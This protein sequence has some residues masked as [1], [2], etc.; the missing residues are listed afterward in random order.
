MALTKSGAKRTLIVFTIVNAAAVLTLASAFSFVTS[1]DITLLKKVLFTYSSDTALIRARAISTG[2]YTGS[3]MSA[4][5]YAK[6]LDT[7]CRAERE[8]LSVILFSKT[9]DENYFTVASKIELDPRLVIPVEPKSRVKESEADWLKKG[10]YAPCVNP[11]LFSD[12]SAYWNNA[13]VPVTLKE[14][15]FV[16]RFSVSSAS[17]VIALENH[18]RKIS[19]VQ[20]AAVILTAFL[21]VVTLSASFIFLRNFSMLMSGIAGY[22]KKAA[23]GN[24]DLSLNEDADEDLFEI[25][26]SFNTLVGEL[27]EKERLISHLRDKT[28]AVQTAEHNTQDTKKEEEFSMRLSALQSELSQALAEKEKMIA[29]SSRSDELSES[30]RAGVD[31]LKE[32]RTAEAETIFSALTILKPD[33]FGAYFNLGVVYAKKRDFDRAITMFERAIRINPNHEIAA[34]YIDKVMRLKR[35]EKPMGKQG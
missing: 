35:N 20:I 4:S 29:E 22:A 14:G 24:T 7:Q 5:E 6:R 1:R 8:I 27:K 16:V 32:G 34:Q 10:L 11:L 12:K 33:G 19:R 18:I 28:R 2:A 13:Y 17:A 30:F 9:S 3:M 15:Q 21:I 26:M 31:F 25:A 23:N